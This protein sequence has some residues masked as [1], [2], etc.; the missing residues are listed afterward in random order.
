LKF[1]RVHK[2]AF[3]KSSELYCQ[4]SL[5][6]LMQ[7]GINFV[8]LPCGESEQNEDED[9]YFAQKSLFTYQASKFRK[10][11]TKV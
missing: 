1:E 6:V 9:Y 5:K 11:L 8:N 4:I 7:V 10:Y 3:K 2:V